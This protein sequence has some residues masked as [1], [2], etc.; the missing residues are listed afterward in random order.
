[1][2]I[3]VGL[4]AAG[5]LVV[6][7]A[8]AA[9]AAPSP[10]PIFIVPNTGSD[11]SGPPSNTATVRDQASSG[12][13]VS[14]VDAA[15]GRTLTVTNNCGVPLVA[16]V[17]DQSGGLLALLTFPNGAATQVDV[18]GAAAI[19]FYREDP[20]NVF[21]FVAGDVFIINSQAPSGGTTPPP[22]LQQVGLLDGASCTEFEAEELNWAGVSSGG[23]DQS[24]AKW[25]NDGLGGPICT[26]TLVYSNSQSRWVLAD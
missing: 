15:G 25:M 16:R 6:A 21:N 3:A 7:N 8:V 13:A 18:T 14:T 10:N 11:C 20:T 17:E 2:R 22:V 1:M 23:W 26:R 12:T 19:T 9:V 24:W 4:A 5:V